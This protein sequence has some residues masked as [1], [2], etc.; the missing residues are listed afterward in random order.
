MV[1]TTPCLLQVEIVKE[2]S[3]FLRHPLMEELV[4]ANTYINEVSWP[5]ILRQSCHIT[6]PSDVPQQLLPQQPPAQGS[7]PCCELQACRCAPDL[8]TASGVLLLQDAVQ[9]MKVPWQLPAG[10]QGEA[11]VR[12]GQVLPVHDAHPAAWR[13]S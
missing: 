2:R 13:D 5:H 3:D 11:R 1:M 6:Q 10:P 4:N 7:V 9:L 12:A 8:C